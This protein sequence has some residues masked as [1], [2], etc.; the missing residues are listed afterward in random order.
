M[1]RNRRNSIALIGGI[2]ISGLLTLS[3][4]SARAECETWNLA[5]KFSLVQSNDATAVFQLTFNG[6]SLRGSAKVAYNIVGGCSDE[7]CDGGVGIG[8]ASVVKATVDGVLDGNSVELTAYWDNGWVGHYAGT[9][10]AQGRM[11]GTGY[12][13]QSPDEVV[14]WYSK[15]HVYCV[16]SAPSLK[17]VL[18]GGGN[19]NK[20]GSGLSVE[21]PGPLKAQGRVKTGTP[22]TGPKLTICEKWRKARDRNSPAA[23]V[24]GLKAQCLAS[25]ELEATEETTE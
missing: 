15:Q 12:E 2:A 24:S 5:G 4:H 3:S 13:R 25:G 16:G 23:T 21:E 7:T 17:D 1:I 18:Q 11:T 8:A 22:S 6:N 14:T 10:N 19:L 20:M 9:I